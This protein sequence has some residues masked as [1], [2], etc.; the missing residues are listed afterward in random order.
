MKLVLAL[1]L[2]MTVTCLAQI[3]P[4][5]HSKQA[6][7]YR[8]SLKAIQNAD[9]TY[10]DYDDF[11]QKLVKQEQMLPTIWENI[12]G[13]VAG[14]VLIDIG[15]S[16]LIYSGVIRGSDESKGIDLNASSGAA[17]SFIGIGSI[18]IGYNLY[19]II[20]DAPGSAGAHNYKRIYEIYK[21][22]RNEQIQIDFI[23]TFGLD[24]SSAGINLLLR[25]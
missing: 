19:A 15:T 10:R 16:G 11:Y 2:T 3:V 18:L 12:V 20:R 1:L 23:P 14:S 22:R 13:C 6:Q 24:N 5:A 17:I 7:F 25:L 9:D 8:D 4:N 21:R